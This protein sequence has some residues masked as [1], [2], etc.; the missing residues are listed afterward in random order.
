MYSLLNCSVG[1]YGLAKFFELTQGFHESPIFLSPE[2][3]TG[4][5]QISRES[6]VYSFSM[7]LYETWV[8]LDPWKK[9]DEDRI[10]Q[11]VSKKVCQ[12]A[13]WD[14]LFSGKSAQ[15]PFEGSYGDHRDYK[16]LLGWGTGPEAI[17]FRAFQKVIIYRNASN[18]SD[19]TRSRLSSQWSKYLKLYVLKLF[20]FVKSPEIRQLGQLSWLAWK[21]FKFRWC[22]W[23]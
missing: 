4:S 1:D 7:I 6:D 22:F 8:A 17:L 21:H 2:I 10:T 20:N 16:R 23:C 13:R 11:E 19:L 14:W 9:Y 3:L 18:S 12:F 5:A 15:N